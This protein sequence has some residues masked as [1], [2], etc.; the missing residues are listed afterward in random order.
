M[1]NVECR[2]NTIK[3]GEYGLITPS[4]VTEI[5]S[6]EKIM[7]NDG[8]VTLELPIHGTKVIEW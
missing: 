1:W 4:E 7:I 2:Q 6:G 8:S 3:L 5:W